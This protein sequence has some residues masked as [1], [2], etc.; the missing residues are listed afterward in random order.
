[1]M[2]FFGH[3]AETWMASAHVIERRSRLLHAASR[4]PLSADYAELGRMV[5][6]KVDALTRS[7]IAG[8]QAASALHAEVWG[9]WQAGLQILS[10]GGWPARGEVDAF[11]AHFTRMSGIAL[12]TG[13]HMLDPVRKR[14]NSNARRLGHRT[15]NG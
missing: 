6:E 14:V 3:I 13:D 15:G 4:D 11:M 8:A 5:P 7:A 9:S 10:S 1:M 2:Q 12:S